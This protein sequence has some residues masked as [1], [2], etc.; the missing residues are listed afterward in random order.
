MVVELCRPAETEGL[1]GHPTPTEV[2]R[3]DYADLT[4]RQ[5]SRRKAE[6]LIDIARWAAERRGGC[7][8]WLE[9][10]ATEVATELRALRGVGEWTEQYVLMRGCGFGDCLPVGDAGLVKALRSFHGLAE[11]P[12]AEA[13]RRLLAPLS[14]YRSLATAHLWASLYDGA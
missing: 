14:P 10:P 13:T 1:R 4:R 9:R 6:Y 7:E 11:R 2:A 3:L 5:F 12:D 8:S